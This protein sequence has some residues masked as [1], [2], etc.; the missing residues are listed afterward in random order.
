MILR[1]F[2]QESVVV[3][4]YS[5]KRGRSFLLPGNHLEPILRGVIFEEISRDLTIFQI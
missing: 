4:S 1:L 3:Q 2:F 5:V